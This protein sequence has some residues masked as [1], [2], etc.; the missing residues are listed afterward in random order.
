MKKL[1]LFLL[2]LAMLAAACSEKKDVFYLEKGSLSYELAEEIATKFPPVDPDRTFILIKTNK[3]RV[4]AMEAIHE[5][6]LN[7]GLDAQR[8]EKLGADNIKGII[9]EN[10]Y[11]IAERKILLYTAEKSG[12]KVSESE[13]VDALNMQFEQA[14]G[15][16]KFLELIK[17][18]GLDIEYVK[19]DIRNNLMK[20]RYLQEKVFSNMQISEEEI[21]ESYLRD[22]TA[23]IRRIFMST[24]G[25]EIPEKKKIL[26]QAKDILRRAKEGESFAELAEE[27]SQDPDS[28]DKGG[29]YEDFGHGYLEKLLD[30]AAFSI[31]QGE[32]SDIIETPAGY[33]IIKVID[34]KKESRPFEEVRH[35]IEERIRTE[36]EWNAY[37]SHLA[38]LRKEFKIRYAMF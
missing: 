14:G 37:H 34:R 19:N 15:E 36:K 2:V 13:I 28:R 38:G 12:I 33:N 9:M 16:E 29:L 8:L 26:D 4:T 20:D 11:K 35:V 1:S 21:R 22:K 18:N 3:F 17:K 27:Y 32:I 6:R 10:A 24:A 7:M 23:T 31:P 30:E 5:A 25:K